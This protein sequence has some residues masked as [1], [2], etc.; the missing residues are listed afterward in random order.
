MTI[1]E[2]P[3]TVGELRASG[4]RVLPVREDPL[5][6]LV[7]TG[8]LRFDRRDL[9]LG[10]LDSLLREIFRPIAGDVADQTYLTEGLVEMDG[11]EGP[12]DQARLEREVFRQLWLADERDKPYAA[13]L[14]ELTQ[15]A[16]GMVL[17]NL[18]AADVADHL[19]AE[20]RKLRQGA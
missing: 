7:L 5:A 10:A 18:P 14:A 1:A 13:A 8:Q 11:G 19:L 3:R 20:L 17:D 12:I 2:K 16:K 15:Q 6:F 4:Y 9:D